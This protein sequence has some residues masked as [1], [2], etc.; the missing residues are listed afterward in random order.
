VPERVINKLLE[1][2]GVVIPFSAMVKMQYDLEYT[3]EYNW[4]YS[5]QDAE[6]DQEDIEDYAYS[7][8]DKMKDVYTYIFTG[9]YPEDD[10]MDDDEY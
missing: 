4:F 8:Q 7:I 2:S 10:Y 6:L 3:G 9:A 5:M 1:V